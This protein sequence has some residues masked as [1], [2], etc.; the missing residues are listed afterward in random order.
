MTRLEFSIS[1]DKQIV[2]FHEAAHCVMAR[3]CGATVIN[4]S[5]QNS[6]GYWS[7]ACSHH[8]SGIPKYE[9]LIYLAGQKGQQ[10]HHFD[11][12]SLKSVSDYINCFLLLEFDLELLNKYKYEVSNIIETHWADVEI[13]ASALLEFGSLTGEQVEGALRDV[14]PFWVNHSRKFQSLGGKKRPLDIN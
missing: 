2:A 6:E 8:R 11:P 7:G 3:L 5:I 1:N 13:V 10:K 14:V 9:A 12:N 4:V